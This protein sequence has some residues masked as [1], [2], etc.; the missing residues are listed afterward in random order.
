MN[1]RDWMVFS[2]TAIAVAMATTATAPAMAQNTTAAVSGQVTDADGKPLAGATVVIVHVESGSTNTLTTDADGR[3]GAR[4][5]RA[6]G[7][8]T[9]TVSKGGL[10]DKRDDVFLKLAE[11]ASLDAT[12]GATAQTV[13]VT[14]RAASDK[15]NRSAM[16]AGT[17]IGARELAA[18]ASVAR[19]LQDYA[20]LDPRLVQTD[21]GN[22][23]I[24][25]AGQNNR[26]N[27]VTIDGVT[28][29]D[30]FGLEANNLPT[31]KQP[32]SIDA[33]AAVQVNLSNYDVTQNGYTGANINAVT[34][35]GT[36]DFHGSVY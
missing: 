34:N 32:I 10:V 9:V 27:S 25:A 12:L 17:N 2:R 14:G 4:G 22:G 13:V 24:S 33:I 23:S 21:K 3:Y 35:S 7:P 1:N 19:N 8:Y 29:S 15:F 18:Q 6:G 30:T 31:K 5:L 28:T 26:F 36:N 11:T 16:G 20:R